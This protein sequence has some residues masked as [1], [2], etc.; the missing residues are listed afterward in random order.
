LA[1]GETTLDNI[2]Q[3]CDVLVMLQIL[4]EMGVELN[5]TR[6][7]YYYKIPVRPDKRADSL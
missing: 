7:G 6:M 4:D 5:A 2:P 3:I 1:E